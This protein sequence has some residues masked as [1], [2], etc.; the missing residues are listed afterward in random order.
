MLCITLLF[1]KL[2]IFRG[3]GGRAP[4]LLEACHAHHTNPQCRWSLSPIL[5]ATSDLL[6]SLRTPHSLLS[7]P[8]TPK[9]DRSFS[10]PSMDK[11]Q[12]THANYYHPNPHTPSKI[13]TTI[14][15]FACL[16]HQVFHQYTQANT[17]R[18]CM[19]WPHCTCGTQWQV[20]QCKWINC[21]HCINHNY[22]TTYFDFASFQA[23]PPWPLQLSYTFDQ[24]S[25]HHTTTNSTSYITTSIFYLFSIIP[26]PLTHT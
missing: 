6:Q 7:I 20:W 12:A 15:N 23:G 4:P 24:H 13:S 14:E 21:W 18:L 8:F 17:P 22:N 26:T 2:W 1:F 5:Y 19:A 10:L 11:N 16:K 9:T 3:R 25:R